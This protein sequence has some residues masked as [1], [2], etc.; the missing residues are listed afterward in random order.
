[1]T[2]EISAQFFVVASFNVRLGELPRISRMGVETIS[3]AR[4]LLRD[5]PIG[6]ERSYS[7]PRC[8]AQLRLLLEQQYAVTVATSR[9]D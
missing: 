8:P 1:M 2:Q 7:D 6:R 5:C 4:F 3:N 9:N